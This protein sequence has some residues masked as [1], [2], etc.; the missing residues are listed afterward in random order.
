MSAG[1]ARLCGRCDRVRPISVRA[2]A[3]GPDICSGCY[4]PPAAVCTVCAQHRPCTGITAGKAICARCRPRTR[5]ICA[6]CGNCRPPAVN[7]AEGPICDPCY[8]TALRHRGRCSGCDRER[9][10]VTSPNGQA[11]HCAD[12]SGTPGLTGHICHDCGREDKLYQ[13]DRC[14]ACS[15]R[16]RVDTLLGGQ[17]A[18]V[19][20]EFLSIRDAIVASA[21]PRTALNWLRRGAGAPLLAALSRGELACSHTA[22]DAHPQRR[23]AD[24]L[25]ALLVAHGALPVRDEALARLERTVADLLAAVPSEQDRRVVT[26]Y[27]TW[28]VLHRARRDTARRPAPSTTTRNARVRLRAATALLQWA[29]ER[30]TGL[31]ELRQADLDQWQLTGPPVLRHEVRDFLTWTAQRR[32]TPALIVSRPARQAG[33]ATTEDQRWALLRGLLH[34]PDI[35]VI[36]RVT[37]SFLLLYGQQLSRIATMTREQIHDRGDRIRVRFGRTDIDL[38][39]PLAGHLRAHLAHPRRHASLGAPPKS[40][41]LFPG[42]LPDRPITAARLGQRLGQLGINAQTGRRATLLQ[43]AAQVPAA[44][45]ADLLGIA[46]TTAADWTHA[47]GGDWSHYAAATARAHTHRQHSPARVAL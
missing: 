18:T 15:L 10:V 42:H 24:Y 16:L 39:Q 28:R 2:S 12:C 45:L 1:A 23:G 27:A 25:R 7:W 4:R 8:T 9:R 21:S 13:R 22:L 17:D 47:A 34:N 20:V 38:A 32:L 31:A 30:G 43:L 40:Q 41:W 6:R 37:G 36:D 35:A 19:S 44:V 29:A 46:V 11:T 26:A 5:R 3:S 33:E 14:A